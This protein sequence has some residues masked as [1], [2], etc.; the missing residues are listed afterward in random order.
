M[1]AKNCVILFILLMSA[2]CIPLA[3]LYQKLLAAG[4]VW[5]LDI[6]TPL[7]VHVCIKLNYVTHK[8][9]SLLLFLKL[10]R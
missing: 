9:K 7:T 6:T 5:S 10:E 3:E 1:F 4:C 8:I 2:L